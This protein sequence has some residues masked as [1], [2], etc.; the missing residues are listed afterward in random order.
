MRLLFE[1]YSLRVPLRQATPATVLGAF[2]SRR[3][4]P[5][6]MRKTPPLTVGSSGSPKALTN[7]ARL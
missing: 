2:L 1:T 5:L 4:W 7:T 6:R 3:A